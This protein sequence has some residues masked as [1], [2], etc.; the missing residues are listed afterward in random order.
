MQKPQ[1]ALQNFKWV[2]ANED[3]EEANTKVRVRN[4]ALKDITLPFVDLNILNEAIAFFEPFGD[5]HYRRGLE[6]MAQLN[7]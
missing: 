1:V 2:I 6:S 5:P 3:T 4:E 7:D